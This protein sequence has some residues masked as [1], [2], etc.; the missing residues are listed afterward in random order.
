MW[1]LVIALCLF[2]SNGE[3]LEHTYK[4]SISEC[5][6]SKRIMER[7]MSQGVIITCGEVEAQIEEV[8]GQTFIR[9]IRKKGNS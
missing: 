1:K 5:L 4:T 3:L 9:S 7:N 2:G 6:K 8:Q